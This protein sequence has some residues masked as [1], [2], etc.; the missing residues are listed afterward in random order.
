[1]ALLVGFTEE[2]MF[3]GVG[4]NVFRQNGFSEGH[5]ALWTSVIFGLVHLSNAFTEGSSAILQAA[6]VAT[7][8]YFFY[9]AL[10]AGHGLWLP[11]LVHALWDFSLLSSLAGPDEPDAYFG[12]VLVIL[13]QVVLIVVTLLRRRRVDPPAG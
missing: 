5:V 3:R 2:L 8:G 9:L 10:R 11:I 1:M 6:V 12:I 7:S 13:L 4:V